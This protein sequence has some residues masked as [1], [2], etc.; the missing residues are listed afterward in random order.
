MG[1][2]H[3]ALQQ[4]GFLGTGAGQ[5]NPEQTFWTETEGL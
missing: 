5:I 2:L 1:A 4:G 3:A